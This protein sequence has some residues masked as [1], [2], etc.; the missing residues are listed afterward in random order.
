[1]ETCFPCLVFILYASLF[2]SGKIQIWSSS[3]E[4]VLHLRLLCSLS[5]SAFPVIIWN[6]LFQDGHVQA[7]DIKQGAAPSSGCK[8]H[9]PHASLEK[10]VGNLAWKCLEQRM[11]TPVLWEDH[12]P[13]SAVP[14][15]TTLL[16]N[17]V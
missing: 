11:H 17:Q 7:A 12:I 15:D 6:A 3:P 13:S 2:F 9:A 1:M 4:A 10:N 8:Q 16:G 14:S 5:A